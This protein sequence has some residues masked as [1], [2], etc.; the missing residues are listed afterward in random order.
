[1][2]LVLFNFFWP[3]IS[4]GPSRLALNYI[5]LVDHTRHYQPPEVPKT[6]EV[7]PHILLHISY[8]LIRDLYG[9]GVY[10]IKV[11]PKNSIRESS[12]A[13]NEPRAI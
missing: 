5:V 4:V 2:W 1:M 11:P 13:L 8:S 12:G 6:P 7:N 9:L 10:T 3:F